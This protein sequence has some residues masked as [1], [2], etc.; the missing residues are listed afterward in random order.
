MDKL[1]AR[2]LR[3]RARAAALSAVRGEHHR[4]C[5]RRGVRDGVTRMRARA[6]RC[7]WSTPYHDDPGYIKALAAEHQRLLG[8]ERPART[9]C[10]CRSTACRGERLDL[11]DPYHC[12]CHKT[13]RLV[14]S[15]LGLNSEQYAVS[16]QSRFGRARWLKPYTLPTLLALAKERVR[17][18]DVACP[19][20]VSDCLETL[21]E[22]GPRRAGCLSRRR[23]PGAALHSLPERATRVDRRA[24]R[25][26]DAQS[27]GLARSAG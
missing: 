3:P 10:C 19:G 17:R 6:R 4:V 21:E 13:A 23:R 24:G 20:F 2:R 22:I 18:V 25:P 12:H 7:A 15:E 14:A 26:G 9:S 11:G 1:K 27:P 16:F 8:E 5:A